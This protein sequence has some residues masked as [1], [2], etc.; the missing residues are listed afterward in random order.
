MKNIK[1]WHIYRANLDPVVGS[2]Q[3]KSRPVLVISEDDIND[4]LNCVNILP[5]TSKQP[6]RFVYPNEVFLPSNTGGLPNESLVLCHQIRTIDKKRLSLSY[7]DVND[8]LLQSAI[9][10]AIRFQLGMP[11]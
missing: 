7:G 6:Q 5:I 1:K 8:I 10:D 9:F 3:G 2:E 11:E 4:L